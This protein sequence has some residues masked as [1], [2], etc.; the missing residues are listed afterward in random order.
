MQP[1]IREATIYDTIGIQPR[2]AECMSRG[3]SDYVD[4]KYYPHGDLASYCQKNRITPELQSKWF[5][6][7]LEAVVV[8]HRH[9]VIH[10]DLALRQFF[11]DDNLDLRLGDFNSS[12][13]PGH[14]ALGYEK[15]SHCL[16]RD[17][18]LPN[19]EISDIFAL[20][21]T[22]YEL[23]VGRAPYSELNPIR[24][25]SDDPD[26]IKAR[27]QRQHQVDLEIELR[28]KNH[29]FPDVSDVFRGD[30]ILGCWRGDFSTAK[31]ALGLYIKKSAEDMCT[32]SSRSKENHRRVQV[33]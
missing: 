29:N 18:E 9:G 16:P 2:I 24:L 14:P 13:Y 20:G 5:Q 21:S 8:I 30:I 33:R 4:V 31:E 12:Q 26:V 6:Q 17:Y 10:S 19:T 25:E 3:R 22:L 23:V 7:I 11:V 27:I 1:I 15:A 32:N 28:Y